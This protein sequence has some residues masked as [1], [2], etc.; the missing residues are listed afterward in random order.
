MAQEPLEF[1]TQTFRPAAGPY[2]IF[3]V[4][5]SGVLGHLEPTGGFVLNYASEP[6]VFEPDDGSETVAIVDQQLAMHVMLGLGVLDILQVDVGMPVYFVNDGDEASDVENGVIGDLV[7]DSKLEIL[8]RDRFGVG[9]AGGLELALPTGRSEALVGNPGVQVAPGVIADYR[10][11]NV[12]LAA[13]LG[14]RIREDV[15]VRNV[16]LGERVEWGLG[17][18]ADFLNGLLRLGGE[19]YG[20]SEFDDPFDGDQTPVEGILGAKVVS[21][22]GFSVSAGAG[23]GLVGGVGAPEFRAF[24][25]LRYAMMDLDAD[26]DGIVDYQDECPNE[27]EDL[28]GFQDMD[29]CP[30]PDNDGDG[31]PDE[32]DRCPMEPGDPDNDGCP[33]DEP[34]E[35]AEP[36]EGE[37]VDEETSEEETG[38]E[39]TGEDE[40]VADGADTDGDGIP[41]SDDLCPETPEDLDGFE[42]DDGCPDTDNDRDG[43]PDVEDECPDKPGLEEDDGCPPEEEKAT[44]TDERIEITERVFFES[45]KAV[46]KPE[47]H[48]LLEQ[49]GLV[50]R[51]NPDID[52]VEIGGHTDNQ[53]GG[54]YNERLSEARARAV[55]AFLVKESDIDEA[56]L[57]AKGYGSSEPI[58]EGDSDESRSQNRRVEFNILEQDDEE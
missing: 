34:S 19:L 23:G 25:G 56:R 27:P 39:E 28:D 50:L 13:N 53:G 29:G 52:T 51:T 35:P 38:E 41:N 55:K 14:M 5:T 46:I 48:E 54:E 2:S 43:I 4:E 57:V 15:A 21:D 31:V 26:D 18:E 30:D 3:T 20:R 33:T 24:I 8:P 1:D 17:A 16:D 47:S 37:P 45:D 42:D 22:T 49:V 36:G 9:L 58:A 32:E 44:R 7:V 10:I 11:E 6:L 40:P 12:T